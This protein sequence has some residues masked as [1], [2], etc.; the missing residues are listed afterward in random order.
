[1]HGFL[2]LVLLVWKPYGLCTMDFSR[3]PG[4]LLFKRAWAQKE[5]WK[6]QG[7]KAF[8][9]R[10]RATSVRKLSRT[11]VVNL[12]VQPWI[13]LLF[14]SEKNRCGLDILNSILYCSSSEDEHSTLFNTSRPH[15]DLPKAN[16]PP[17]S[18]RDLIP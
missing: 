17:D 8:S 16:T 4:G 3:P 12:Q 5:F 9:P 15:I 10:C 6:G 14:A 1:M 18:K 2:W 13:K 11:M 7:T